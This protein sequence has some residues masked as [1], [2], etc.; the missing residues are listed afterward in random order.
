MNTVTDTLEALSMG[1]PTNF[2]NLTVFPLLGTTGY[3]RNYLTLSEAVRTGKA[4]V[5][6]VSKGGSVPE[7]MLKNKGKKPVLILE[8]EE[9]IGAK[10][11]RTA[12]VTILAPAKQTVRIP[13]TCVESGRWGYE[14]RDLEPSAQLHFASGRINK[15]ASVT[16]SMR[17]AGTRSAS[18]SDVWRDIDEKT[19]RMG[20]SAPTCAMNDVFEANRSGLDD[21]VGAFHAGADQTGALFAIGERI[22]GVELFD[23]PQ[24][25][26]ELLPKLIRSY[27]I[28]A[29]ESAA[30][31]GE[32]PT[33]ESA[34]AFIRRLRE[35]EFESYAAVG[36]GTEVRLSTPEVIAA[37]LVAEGR[38]V[39]MAAFGAPAGAG[40][41]EPDSFGFARMGR[42]RQGMRR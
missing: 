16:E 27:A 22:E 3:E 19:A 8:G 1:D 6:E 2:L 28:D 35:A 29:I 25:M 5:R 21:Y 11:N 37:G 20:V 39:H 26:A 14:G 40:R 42:R 10:Q 41:S 13:V 31:K 9:L 33:K 23:C 7:L 24:T 30:S 36:E 38:V 34:E 17:H 4:S 15:M 12:N 18:Q 32:G